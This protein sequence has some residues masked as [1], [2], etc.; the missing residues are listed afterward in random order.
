MPPDPTRADE[1]PPVETAPESLTWALS[2]EPP[3][4]ET[5]EPF[6]PLQELRMIA[7]RPKAVRVFMSDAES[8]L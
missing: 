2:P 1:D 3:I 5:P 7:S 8:Q 6:R 4:A